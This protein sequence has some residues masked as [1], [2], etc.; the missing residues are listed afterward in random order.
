MSLIEQVFGTSPFKPLLEHAKKVNECVGLIRPLMKALTEED[1]KQIRT[2]QDKVSK[3]E[4]EADGIKHTIRE[5]VPRRYFLPVDRSDLTRYLR[6]QDKIADAV[7]DFAV[8]LIIRN[9]RIHPD[10]VDE[11][12]EY[13]EHV[14][15]LSNSLMEAAQE[16]VNLAE[17]SFGGEE[18][19][20]VL[21]MINGL[22]EGEW[23]ADRMQREISIHIYEKEDILDPVTIMFY[24]KIL[25]AFSQIANA[26]E[27][28]GDILRMMIV[29]EG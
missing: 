27:N 21:N 24:E 25:M 2:L 3:L 11:I 4:Y 20:K 26:V 8:I 6:M 13:S 18:A 15:S 10:F 14:I 28:T 5:N 29:K 16:M 22:G 9:T 7:E 12:M 19:R 1:Y 17:T 23:K